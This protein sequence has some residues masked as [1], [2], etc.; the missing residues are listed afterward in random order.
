MI[1]GRRFDPVEYASTAPAPGNSSA[2]LRKIDAQQGNDA[3]Q[4]AHEP[5]AYRPDLRAD[6][7]YNCSDHLN[8]ERRIS[9]AADSPSCHGR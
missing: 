5:D 4:A 7:V 1:Y 8:T 6:P 9:R 2:R 3:D